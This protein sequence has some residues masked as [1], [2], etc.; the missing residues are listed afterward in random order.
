MRKYSSYILFM[1][2]T[3]L[4]VIISINGVSPLD[5]LQRSINDF[6]SSVTA[7][8]E[9][10]GNILLVT[11]D[12]P[13]IEKYGDWPWK[14]DLIADLLAATAQGEPKV[15]AL[16]FVISEDS[17]QD[18]VGLTD[19]LDGQLS[20]IKNLVVPYDIALTSY[21]DNRTNNPK[22]LFDNSVTVNNPLG[23]MDESSSLLVRKVFLPP[24]KIL[25]NRQ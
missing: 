18:S 10:D 23:L 6:L 7:T 25:K 15:I 12:K 20:W 1:L 14:H 17:Y 8:D 24:E 16:D 4:V 21:R 2:I 13:A 3:F 22:Y 11:I 9:I 19:I 5:N